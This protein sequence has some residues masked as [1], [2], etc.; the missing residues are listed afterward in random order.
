MIRLVTTSLLVT[1]MWMDHLLFVQP[2][3]DMFRL[4]DNATFVKLGVDTVTMLFCLSTIFI[5]HLVILLISLTPPLC[6][7]SLL[8]YSSVKA[9]QLVKNYSIELL[10][11]FYFLFFLDFEGNF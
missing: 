10:L 6:Y 2:F 7:L 3:N 9:R 1:W 4:V 8:F 5:Y 11:I